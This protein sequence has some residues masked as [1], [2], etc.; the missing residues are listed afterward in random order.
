MSTS[1]AAIA[2]TIPVVDTVAT[3]VFEV[4][5]VA[6]FVTL[7]CAPFDIDAIAVSWDVPPT[8]GAEPVTATDDTGGF[9]VDELD[10]DGP[11]GDALEPPHALMARIRNE[12]AHAAAS[13]RGRIKPPMCF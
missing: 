9:V 12:A 3:L 4:C 11:D 2:E 1:P 6:R 7:V 10:G 5:H 8:M 13:R